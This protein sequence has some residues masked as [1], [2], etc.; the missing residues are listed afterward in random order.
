M[1]HRSGIGKA[2]LIIGFVKNCDEIANLH[3]ETKIKWREV[4]TSWVVFLTSL[5]GRGR[6]EWESSFSNISNRVMTAVMMA[7]PL[8]KGKSQKPTGGQK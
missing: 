5:G 1:I 3:P 2:S 8:G 4:L 6:V 7:A